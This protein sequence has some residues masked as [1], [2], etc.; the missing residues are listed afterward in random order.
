M[1]RGRFVLPLGL[2]AVLGGISLGAGRVLAQAHDSNAPIDFV[3]DRI[4]VQDRAH[5]AVWSGNVR[6][7][8]QEM[9]IVADRMTANYTGSLGDAGGGATPAPGAKPAPVKAGPQL[10]RIDATGHVVVTRPTE[11]ARGDYGIY[12][13]NSKLI[14]LLGHVSLDRSG[15]IVRGGR[16][17]IDQNTG[18]AT[19]DGSA[20][21]GAGSAGTGGRVS[22]RF[23]VANSGTAKPATPPAKP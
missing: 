20:V 19:V 4:E 18:R 16:L 5:R 10:Q 21:G 13:L 7:V 1:I 15:S 17:V 11:V 12:D 8:Q 22:G 9:T 14:T 3:A 2:V 6:A 23:T